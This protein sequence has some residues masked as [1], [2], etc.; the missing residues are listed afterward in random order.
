MKN[1]KWRIVNEAG[2]AAIS[3]CFIH[4]SLFLILNFRPI[5]NAPES[6]LSAA[7]PR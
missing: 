7:A 4:Y 6:E 3:F 1:S 5:D 2:V